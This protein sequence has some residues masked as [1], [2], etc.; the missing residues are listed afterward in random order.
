MLC[1]RENESATS[2]Y[3]P[4]CQQDP[5]IHDLVM[6]SRNKH[7][8]QLLPEPV[9]LGQGD[10]LMTAV[11]EHWKRQAS[12]ESHRRLS[13]N[14][15]EI[16]DKGSI[17]RHHRHSRTRQTS[18][19]DMSQFHTSDGREDEIH[20]VDHLIEHGSPFSGMGMNDVV[21]L[22]N[23][24]VLSVPC[25][26]PKLI[27]QIQSHNNKKQRQRRHSMPHLFGLGKR[28]DRPPHHPHLESNDHHHPLQGSGPTTM[29]KVMEIGKHIGHGTMVPLH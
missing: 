21:H 14:K 9:T 8:S 20:Q 26:S 13:M 3:S 5:H 22:K 2:L 25:L 19:P 28:E 10:P 1:D 16:E 7:A 18:L 4:P 17:R 12:E 15:I 11:V 6:H 29:A 23:G 27:H 24:T